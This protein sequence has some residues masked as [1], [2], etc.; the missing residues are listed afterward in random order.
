MHRKE[1]K[2]IRDFLTAVAHSKTKQRRKK[3]ENKR[4]FT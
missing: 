2:Q 4:L 3:Q 1:N